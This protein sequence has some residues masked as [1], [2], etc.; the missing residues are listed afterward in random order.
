MWNF[1]TGGA[2][3]SSPSISDKEHIFF[4]SLDGK[5]Y[6]I[7]A[8][9]EQLWSYQTGD[10]VVSSPAIG[11]DTALVIGSNDS[12]LYK[13]G[14][15]GGLKW[16]FKTGGPIKCSPAIGGDGNIYFG[17]ADGYIYSVNKK[18]NENWKFN[19]NSP[20]NGSPSLDSFENIFIGCDDGRLLVLDKQGNLKWYLKTNDNLVAPPLVTGNDVIYVGSMDGYIYIIKNNETGLAKLEYSNTLEWPTFK[21]NNRRTGFKGDVESEEIQTGDMVPQ[22]YI[23]FQNYPNPFN[24]A[25]KIKIG[26][27]KG[28]KVDIS[29]YNI[30]GQKIN[31]MLNK[32]IEAGYYELNVD[33]NDLS[34]GIYI[35]TMET[36]E[37]RKSKKMILMK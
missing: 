31:T 16:E 14:L 19:A 18:G 21:G 15:D 36:K 37:F 29:L 3:L 6:A 23:L 5:I 26:L 22:N 27:P 11:N 25:T 30:L 13:I 10:S 33:I 32:Y 8:N 24:S 1:Q 4:G 17:S 35:Y 20:V 7:D 2:I 34:T 12:S 28:S 9:G